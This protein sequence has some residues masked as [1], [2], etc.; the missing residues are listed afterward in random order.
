[1]LW[2]LVHGYATLLIEGKIRRDDHGGPL[3]QMD[4]I[5]PGFGYR[6]NS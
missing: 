3:F 4:E 1:M 5:M 6:P 2:S